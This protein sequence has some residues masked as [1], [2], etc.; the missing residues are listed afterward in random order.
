MTH[1]DQSL[2][3]AAPAIEPSRAAA[4]G[5]RLPAIV[6]LEYLKKVSEADAREYAL[7][8]L[9]N[10]AT[11]TQLHYG[12][13]QHGSGFVVEIQESGPGFAY[14]P[15]LLSAFEQ[16]VPVQEAGVLQARLPM[17]QG[18]LYVS[19]TASDL[20]ALSL[21][22]GS[23]LTFDTE[24]TQSSHR[25]ERVVFDHSKKLL[26]ISQKV[27][28]A[29]LVAFG[30]TLLLKPSAPAISLHPV[31]AEMLPVSQWIRSAA[32]AADEK[33]VAVRLKPG[34]SELLVVTEK[35]EPSPSLLTS[36][37]FD[38]EGQTVGRPS[39]SQPNS[40]GSTP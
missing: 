22:E 12:L 15:S 5:E 36:G 38:T 30:A 39:A 14:T 10:K 17:G 21:P 40:K 37:Q 8:Y 4:P 28:I 6:V 26:A 24:A 19:V 3:P 32:W 33:P 7:G 34:S 20:T 35:I 23:A 29:S 2:T 9:R 18:E 1:P 13:F 11:S 16:G 27:F 25:L 31:S